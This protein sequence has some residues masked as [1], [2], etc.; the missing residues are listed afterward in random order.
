MEAETACTDGVLSGALRHLVGHEV[1]VTVCSDAAAGTL[2]CMSGRLQGL[3]VVPGGPDAPTSI[4]VSGQDV[5]VWP[6]ELPGAQVEASED[7]TGVSLK[8]ASGT[9][10]SVDRV[11]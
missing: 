2:V 5:M 11:D 9:H 4:V 3:L 6:D 10:I 8:L 1:S 7:G